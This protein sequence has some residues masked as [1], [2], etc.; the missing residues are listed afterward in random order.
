MLDVQRVSARYGRAEV[1]REATLQIDRGELVSLVGGNGVGK[2]TLVRSIAGLHTERSGAVRLDDR[3]LSGATG[4]Q[5]ARAGLLLVPQG[6]RLFRSLT[7][8]EHLDLA[9]SRRFRSDDEGLTRAEVLDHFPHL[10]RRTGVRA[11]SLSGGEQQMLAIARAVL[12]RPRYVMFDEPTEGLSPAMVNV[13]AE[14]INDLPS[15]AVGV[16]IT[17]QVPDS[18]VLAKANRHL[19]MYRGVVSE[20]DVADQGDRSGG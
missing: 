9:E 11:G 16:L 2:T 20:V 3:T 19:L 1:V 15:R 10:A 18:E 6:R 14:L 5:T 4:M 17:E 12:Q 7:V 13:V 8:D